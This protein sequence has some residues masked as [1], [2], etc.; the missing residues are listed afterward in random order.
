[1]NKI[2]SSI[3]FLVIIIL[4]FS[5]GVYF[6]KDIYLF[7]GGLNIKNFNKTDVGNL[8]KQVS[9]EI[10][11]PAPLRV[12]NPY[13]DIVLSSQKV[14]TETNIQRNINGLSPLLRNETLDRAATAKANDMLKNQYFEHNSLTGLT[15]ANLVK[16]FGYEYIITGENL[17]LGNFESEAQAVQSWMNSP[18][19]RAN[20]LNKRYA[21]IGIAFVKGVYKGEIVWIGVQE[22]GLSMSA[23]NEPDV[24]LKNTIEAS[25]VKL[26]KMASDIEAKRE[27]INSY[28]TDYQ[29]YNSLI[30]AYNQLV[31]EY[32]NLASQ[33]KNQIAQYNNQVSDFNKC[34]A[35]ENQ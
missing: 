21:E 30:P 29:K 24:G 2:I 1:M 17:I 33:I 27:E 11:N 31:S 5:G 7:L 26:N 23:C 19:H 28:V 12:S 16:G 10:L 34:V 25:E 22:F 8:I 6:S 4:A 18:G 3:I 35:G 9:S 20:I 13:K 15:P 32:Q 14:F